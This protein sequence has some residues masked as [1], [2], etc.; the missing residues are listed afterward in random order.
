MS[1]NTSCTRTRHSYTCI[2]I[3]RRQ[4]LEAMLKIN[5]LDGQTTLKSM[6]P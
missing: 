6:Y 2:M 3:G 4:W 1:Q 5:I